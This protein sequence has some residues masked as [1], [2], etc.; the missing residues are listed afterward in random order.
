LGSDW[1]LAVAMSVPCV[2]MYYG[3]LAAP[4]HPDAWAYALFRR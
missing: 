2:C 1:P 4:S 3:R